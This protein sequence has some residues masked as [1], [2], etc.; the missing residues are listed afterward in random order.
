MAVKAC[1]QSFFMFLC[2]TPY[3]SFK[4]VLGSFDS[5]NGDIYLRELRK[6]QQA[7][8]LFQLPSCSF[9]ENQQELA[10]QRENTQALHRSSNKTQTA[11]FQP[12]LQGA[13][14]YI[15]EQRN[16]GLYKPSGA[17]DLVPSFSAQPCQ[18]KRGRN[19]I[20]K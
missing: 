10:I 3:L 13:G 4:E 18:I 16:P 17:T 5:L 12:H 9:M 6:S 8:V 2:A 7:A 20:G 14:I 11:Q 15:S 19:P 1:I